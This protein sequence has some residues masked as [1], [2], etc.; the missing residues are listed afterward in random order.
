MSDELADTE[1]L[2]RYLAMLSDVLIEARFLAYESA[3]RVAELLDAV[4]NVPDLLTRWPDMRPEWVEADL[5]TYE[6]KY[7]GGE[8]QFTRTLRDG[9]RP[10][11][12]LRWGKE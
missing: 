11:W 5:T 6:A 2:V 8:P 7:L 1:T 10:N 3:P 4:H 9:P 12:Q